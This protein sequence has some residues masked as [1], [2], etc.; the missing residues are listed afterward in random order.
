M[1]RAATGAA[2]FFVLQAGM[3]QADPAAEL[4]K[5]RGE[6]DALV[7]EGRCMNL[8]Q[9]RVVALGS[10]P[11]GGPAEYLA[12]SWIST[13]KGALET[14]I[15]EYGFLQE[16]VHKSRSAAGACAAVPEPAAACVNNRCVLS[17]PR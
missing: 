15:A 17:G 3:A 14:K 1:K 11:C 12:Y 16:D 6:I 9:C 13:D 5:L 2:V 10:T 4:A 7:G 8:V